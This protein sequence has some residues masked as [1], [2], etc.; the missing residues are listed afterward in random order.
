MSAFITPRPVAD[1][2]VSAV[3]QF[4]GVETG[5][6]HQKRGVPRTVVRVRMFCIWLIR[7]ATAFTQG[8]VAEYFDLDHSTVVAAEKKI[9][10]ALQTDTALRAMA[11]SIAHTGGF[12][13]RGLLA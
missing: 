8:E 5:S 11:R 10:K 12:E 3:C 2:I 4:F 13:V 9:N 6:V 1:A 7:H